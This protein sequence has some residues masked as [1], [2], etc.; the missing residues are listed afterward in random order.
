M[1]NVIIIK[2]K[3]DCYLEFLFYFNNQ[4]N[5]QSILTHVNIAAILVYENNKLF[6]SVHAPTWLTCLLLFE[7]QDWVKTMCRNKYIV[8]SVLTL[9]R[10]FFLF[11]LWMYDETLAKIRSPDVDTNFFAVLADVLQGDILAP[12]EC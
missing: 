6:C 4:L 2:I 9:K 1:L 12:N 7:R 11:A 8:L 5:L 10:G 3:L